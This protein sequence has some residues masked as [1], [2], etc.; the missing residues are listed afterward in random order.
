[1]MEKA[2]TKQPGLRRWVKVLLVAS[3]ALNLLFVGLAGGLAVRFGG[4][5]EGRPPPS[6]GAAL[7]R[8]MPDDDR[9][10]LRKELRRSHDR[11]AEREGHR[12][13]VLAIAEL[14]RATPF[15]R[16]AVEALVRTQMMEGP[17]GVTHLR[18]AWIDRVSGMSGAARA[19]YADR[20]I[21]VFD[22]PPRKKRWFGGERRPDRD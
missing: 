1:M 2:D 8:A 11:K 21:E 20:L 4:G 9:R 12:Q 14:L 22:A 16:E 18:A 15:D 19:E 17:R 10:A 5:K 3:L 6:V 7:Y 13:D